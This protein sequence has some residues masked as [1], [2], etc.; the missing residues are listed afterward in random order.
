[1]DNKELTKRLSRI[2]DEIRIAWHEIDDL[3]GESIDEI[4]I[5]GVSYQLACMAYDLDDFLLKKEQP[6]E[7]DET[8]ESL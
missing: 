1:M 7:H 4:D 3:R 8:I 2:A 6:D 5:C